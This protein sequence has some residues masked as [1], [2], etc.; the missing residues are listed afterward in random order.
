VGPPVL[1]EQRRKRNSRRKS[2]RGAELVLPTPMHHRQEGGG[3]V[4]ME[5]L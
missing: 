4:K 3:G 1:R 5:R 2:P